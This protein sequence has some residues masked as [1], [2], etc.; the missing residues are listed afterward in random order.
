MSLATKLLQ[1]WAVLIALG[2]IA[3]L[4]VYGSFMPY[5][6]GSIWPVTSRITVISVV[7]NGTGVDITYTYTK[8]RLCELVGYSAKVA[9]ID[10]LLVPIGEAVGLGT[11]GLGPEAPRQWRLVAPS[12]ANTEIWVIHRCSPLWLTATKIYG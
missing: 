8:Y 7:P 12:L 6:E 4:P 11:R 2:V 10:T 9:G 3:L 1:N 5:V